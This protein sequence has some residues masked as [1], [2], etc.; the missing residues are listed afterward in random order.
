MSTPAFDAEKTA[1]TLLRVSRHGALGTLMKGTGGPYSSLVAVASAPDGAPLLLISR[2]AR[3][4]QNIEA[5]PRVSL[6]LTEA[7]EAP[8]ESPR[9]MVAGTAE[10]LEW[11]AAAQA[12]RRYLAAHPSAEVFADF[13]DFAFFRLAP[14]GLHLVA[15]FGRI[16][17][18][19]PARFLTDVSSAA[20]LIDAEPEILAHLNADHANTLELY[21]TRLLGRENGKDGQLW[22]CVACDCEGLDLKNG[23]ETARLW[24]SEPVATPGQLRG[25]LKTLADLARQRS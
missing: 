23:T 24:F 1:K 20:A 5:D 3:H 25:V 17:D 8:L 9:I 15:G 4:T 6:L 19:K 21:A 14:A 7:S 18:L 16:T 22:R 12:R 11:P 13:G 2:L 10:R